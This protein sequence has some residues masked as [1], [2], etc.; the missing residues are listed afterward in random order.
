[1][2]ELNLTDLAEVGDGLDLFPDSE[3]TSASGGTQ[4]VYKGDNVKKYLSEDEKK[5]AEVKTAEDAKATDPESVAK[6]K[7]N[8][9]VQAGKTAKADEG[10]DSSSPKLNETEQ[11]Y[12]NLATKFKAEGVL[13]GLEDTSSIKS[14]KDLEDAMKTEIESRF[15][16]RSKAIEDAMNAGL[17]A[18][19]I[20]EQM[21][22]IE[23]LEKIDDRYLSDDNNLEFR[24]TAIVQDFLSKG[25][26][27][28][29]ADTMAQRSIDAGTDIDDAKFALASIIS[30]EK[31]TLETSIQAAKDKETKSITDLKEYIG[32]NSFN[33]SSR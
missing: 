5:A 13:P 18:G 6:D 20:A 10:S 33:R 25:Y 31:K 8:T 15:D 14:L 32:K 22:V 29:R 3:D 2:E 16:S 28:E 9:Q 7:E 26:G 27:K 24:R 4:E 19:E 30:S 23:K 17:P 12:S 11:L 21:E 1:M